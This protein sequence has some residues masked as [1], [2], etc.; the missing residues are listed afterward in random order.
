MKIAIIGPG[1]MGLFFAARLQQAGQEVWL[2]DHRP[3]RAAR[4]G[5]NGLIL[6]ELDGTS[7]CLPLKITSDPGKIGPVALTLLL[8]K[9]H[10]TQRAAQALPPLLAGGGIALTL[11]NG[12]GNL[13][14]M[15]QVVGPARLLAGVTMLGVTK[16]AE[17][18]IRHA[19]QGPVILGIPP[20]SRVTVP[21]LAAV[22]QL[23]QQA[24]F[25]CR[26]ERDIVAVL[27]QKLLINVG[28]NPVT[29][30]T[31]LPNGR[32]PEIPWAW[33]V[34]TAAVQEAQ[35]VG[36]AAGVP[37]PPDP[38]ARVEQVCQATAANRSSMLQDILN[39]RP[40][41]IDALNGQIVAH[42]RRLGLATPVNALL[43]NLIKALENASE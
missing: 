2:L 35:K 12:I 43:T 6:E 9:A 3:E 29:A 40:T 15:A 21:E 39:R 42:G 34:V 41:E 31:R 37:L 10:Q 32:L 1:A 25:D 4:L 22:V 8:V 30:L 26:A 28:I 36:L 18:R 11:Q 17:G 20:V 13:E 33:E 19:G 27:W 7:H 5:R 23:C 38:E 24:G 14:Y 16:V